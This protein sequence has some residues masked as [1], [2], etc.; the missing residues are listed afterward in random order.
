MMTKRTYEAVARLIA[1]GT[2]YIEEDRH[3]TQV[4]W[5]KSTD[6]LARVDLMEA[7]VRLEGILTGWD[8]ARDG[9]AEIFTEDNP[10][11]DRPRFMAASDGVK[12]ARVTRSLMKEDKMTTA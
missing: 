6:P 10:R 2:A 1:N 11:F 7:M 5:T 4:R 3:S 12:R 9:L 8:R